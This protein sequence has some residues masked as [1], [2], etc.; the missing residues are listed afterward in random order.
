MRKTLNKLLTAGAVGL[1]VAGCGGDTSAFFKKE[2]LMD[3]YIVTIGNNG[4]ARYIRITQVSD[5]GKLEGP[6]LSAN[7]QNKDGRFD[8]IILRY[9]PK[10]NPMEKYASLDSLNALYDKVLNS[11]SLN[12]KPEA[13]K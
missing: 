11:D 1:A 10:G 3:P 2:K 7:D 5:S 12:Q 13:P 6:F 4:F 9:L 8:E